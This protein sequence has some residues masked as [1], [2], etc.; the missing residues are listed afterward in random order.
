MLYHL[1]LLPPIKIIQKLTIETKKQSIE[2]NH[3]KYKHKLTQISHYYQ[4]K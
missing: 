1:M 4:T 3:P 2:V